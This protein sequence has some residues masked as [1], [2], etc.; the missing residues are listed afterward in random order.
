MV[1]SVGFMVNDYMSVRTK[2]HILLFEL[3]FAGVITPV[4][5]ITPIGVRGTNQ[6]NSASVSPTALMTFWRKWMS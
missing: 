5:L 3:V 2:I 1:T 4:A 6:K